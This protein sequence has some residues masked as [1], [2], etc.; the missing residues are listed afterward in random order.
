MVVW[1]IVCFL[2]IFGQNR[3]YLPYDDL[4]QMIRTEFRKLGDE[5]LKK[6]NATGVYDTVD[7]TQMPVD[8]TKDKAA[9]EVCS[10]MKKVIEIWEDRV[11]KAK[12]EFL[13]SFQKIDYKSNLQLIKT[14]I[15]LAS[16][17]IDFFLLNFNAFTQLLTKIE[18]YLIE[19]QMYLLL[20]NIGPHPRMNNSTQWLVAER[21]F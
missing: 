13:E 5:I 9:Q 20:S 4:K 12:D 21:V 8:R 15:E 6:T 14:E 2:G 1:A 16:V 11:K 18:K 19:Y 7:F 10:E 17:N 3:Q